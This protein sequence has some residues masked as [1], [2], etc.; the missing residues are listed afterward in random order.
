[1]RKFLFPLLLFCLTI[2]LSARHLQPGFDGNEF[3]KMLEVSGH[4]SDTPWVKLWMPYPTGYTLACRSAICGLDNRWDLWTGKDSVDVIS[5]RGTTATYESWLENFYAGMIPAN[6][7][8]NLENGRTFSYRLSNDSGAYV[9]I[10]WMIGLANMAP[11]I[12]QKINEEYQKGVKDF[13]IMGHSQGGAIGFLLT[14]YLHYE[15]GKSIPADITFKTYG[16]AVPKPGN[17]FY[18]YDFDF[19]TRGGWA[20]RVVNTA[21]W[22]PEVPFAIQTLDDLSPGSPFD[23]TDKFTRGSGWAVRWYA[24]HLMKRMNRSA[25]RTQRRFSKYLAKKSGRLVRR[26]IEGFP[27]Q[28]FVESLN[29]ST[30]GLPIILQPDAHYRELYP[31]NGQSIFRHHGFGPYL[32]LINTHYPVK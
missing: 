20:F 13:Y 19:I 28:K 27:K 15:K 30:C 26:Q 24:R 32:Y 10:G 31:D 12:V 8:L 23:D 5:I 25:K 21:D 29:Y 18:A 16:S 22:V 7:T 1:M 17:L 2:S 3:R 14:S 9:H 6:G 4:Q 11:E